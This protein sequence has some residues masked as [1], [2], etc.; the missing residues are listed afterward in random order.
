MKPFLK[1]EGAAVVKKVGFIY[2]FE[3]APSKGK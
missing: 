3:I 2:H 1:T